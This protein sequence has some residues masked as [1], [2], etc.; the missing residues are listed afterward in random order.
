MPSEG[1]ISRLEC[2]KSFQLPQTLVGEL[3]NPLVE[4]K[5]IPLLIPSHYAPNLLKILHKVS[6]INTDCNSMSVKNLKLL[7]K[8]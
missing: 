7:H 5:Q 1:Y 8:F 6:R 4:K 2:S 3:T